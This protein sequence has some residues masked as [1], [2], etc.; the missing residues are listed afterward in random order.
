MKGMKEKK[1]A[2]IKTEH[3]SHVYSEGTPFVK[4]AIQ[5]VNLSIEEGEL[6]GVI[7]HTGSGKSTLIQHLNGLLKPTSG[8]IYIDGQDMWEDKSKLR[9]IRFKVGLVFQY[10]EYQLFEETVY[11]DIAFGPKNMGLSE[12]EV[13]RRVRRAAAFVNVGKDLLDKSPFELSGGQKRR[14]AIAGV[15]AMDPKVLILDE[16]TSGLDPSERVRFRNLLAEFAQG[17]I[18][19]ISTHIVADV[20]VIAGQNA[21]M[22][23]GALIACD[24]TDALVEKVRGKVWTATI[25]AAALPHWEQTL[26]IIGL[27]SE[28]DRRIALRYLAE[29]PLLAGSQA[30][31]PRLEDLFLWLF[32]HTREERM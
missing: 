8:K 5:D 14:V 16:P 21:I 10:P 17:R 13:D 23:D 2:V 15:L 12:E 6:V 24:R 4:M 19:L 26:T 30:A 1:M 9:D 20:E 25:D 32:P 11:K 3:L 22:K 7:G 18:V 27:R 29:T 28:P 31:A